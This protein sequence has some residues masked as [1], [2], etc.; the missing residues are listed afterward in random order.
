MNLPRRLTGRQRE[1][2]ELMGGQV[3]VR[4]LD[5]GGS[6]GSYHSKVMTQLVLKGL[7][8]RRRLGVGSWSYRITPAG[9]AAA[10]KE[11]ESCE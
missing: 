5:F 9:I 8:E 6:V 4:P 3:W 7:C 1:L 2:L 11:G 10:R